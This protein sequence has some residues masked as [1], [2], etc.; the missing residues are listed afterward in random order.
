MRLEREGGQ[1]TILSLS[2]GIGAK[3]GGIFSIGIGW[4]DISSTIHRSSSYT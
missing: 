2:I 1:K 4:R 3:F